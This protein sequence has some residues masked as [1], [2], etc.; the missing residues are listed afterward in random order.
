MSCL[1]CLEQT[2]GENLST[3]GS[4]SAKSAADF[5]LDTLTDID[6]FLKQGAEQSDFG[7]NSSEV[8]D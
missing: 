8:D 3:W 4:M 6:I 5:D 1:P 2:A 7:E